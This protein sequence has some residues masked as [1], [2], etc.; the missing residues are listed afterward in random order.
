MGLKVGT[1]E[2]DAPSAAAL[3]ESRCFIILKS[4]IFN[5][6]LSATSPPQDYNSAMTLM[7]A[8]M[9]T[10]WVQGCPGWAGALQ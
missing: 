6:T 8:G 4:V 10:M 3:V 5:R 9:A 1:G 2:R 7:S